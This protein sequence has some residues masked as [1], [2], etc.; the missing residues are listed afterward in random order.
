MSIVPNF[1]HP[2][3]FPNKTIPIHNDFLFVQNYAVLAE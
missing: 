1:S 3:I 2:G